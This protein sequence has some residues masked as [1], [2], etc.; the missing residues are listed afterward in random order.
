M[1]TDQAGLP[2]TGYASNITVKLRADGGLLYTSINSPVE[3]SSVDAPGVYE[4]ALT[5]VE[6]EVDTLLVIPVPADPSYRAQVVDVSVV[7]I[8]VDPAGYVESIVWAYGSTYSPAEQVLTSPSNKLAT[9]TSGRV[10]V[11]VNADKTG[12][13]LTAAERSNIASAVWSYIVEGT[14]TALNFLRM[15]ASV[16][17]G[18]RSVSGGSETYYGVDDTTV[19]VAGDVDSTGNRTINTRNGS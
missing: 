12:Y 3:V 6:M 8:R 19:R 14:F 10:T 16:C 15:I 11:G 9:D 1:V 17:F 5:A 2:V 13:E 7:P 18:K 4:I